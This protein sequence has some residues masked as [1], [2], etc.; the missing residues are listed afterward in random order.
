M[1]LIF[2][3]VGASL[4]CSDEEEEQPMIQIFTTQLDFGDVLIGAT[5]NPQSIEIKNMSAD[6][7]LKIEDLKI[8]DTEHFDII[9]IYALPFDIEGAQTQIVEVVFD[10]DTV[11]NY[12]SFLRVISNAS[13]RSN[14][15]IELQGKGVENPIII[16][17]EPSDTLN[18]GTV[19]IDS[20]AINSI[21]IKN[22]GETILQI[23]QLTLTTGE[24]FGITSES[25]PFIIN[26]NTYKQIE[27]SFSPTYVGTFEDELTITNNST[28]YPTYII[29]IIGIGEL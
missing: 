8:E 11:G 17:V 6:L 13:N 25:L 9:N 10:P 4:S 26:P 18:F 1:I 23:S 15:A 12:N 20:T 27:I 22:T 28:D 29:H 19:K 16:A 24:F 21:T 7:T 5:S 14:F 2:I 3:A